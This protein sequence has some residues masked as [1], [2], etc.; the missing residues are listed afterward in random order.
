MVGA[1]AGFR[2]VDDDTV[3]TLN[4]KQ[5]VAALERIAYRPGADLDEFIA[6]VRGKI[7]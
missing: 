6:D 4:R 1:D 5:A 3:A 2:D 7:T